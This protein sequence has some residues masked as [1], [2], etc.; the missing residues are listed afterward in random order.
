MQSI[1]FSLFFCLHGSRKA[2]IPDWNVTRM[3]RKVTITMFWEV[4]IESKLNQFQWSWYHSFQ[5]LKE[6]KYAIFSNSKVTEIERSAFWGDTHT[7]IKT[8]LITSGSHTMT[9]NKKFKIRENCT[10]SKLNKFK[11]TAGVTRQI[12]VCQPDLEEICTRWLYVLHLTQKL[13]TCNR[14][15]ITWRYKHN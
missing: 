7:S 10:I 5:N 4:T 6:S 15:S 14:A 9:S 13:L 1:S 12:K 3:K 2:I 11:L 8:R